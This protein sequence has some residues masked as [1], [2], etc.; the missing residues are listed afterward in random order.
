MVNRSL[1]KTKSS[2]YLQYGASGDRI[3]ADNFVAES[4]DTFTVFAFRLRPVDENQQI[5]AR[6]L[7]SEALTVVQL[8]D[9][10]ICEELLKFLRQPYVNATKLKMRIEALGK[11]HVFPISIES[12]DGEM[13]SLVVSAVS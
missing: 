3:N 9:R 13:L 11:E 10:L 2:V 8:D 4:N 1:R 7:V 12:T 6:K 5:D